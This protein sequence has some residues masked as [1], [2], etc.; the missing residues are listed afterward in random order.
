[1]EQAAHQ[2]M[3]LIANWCNRATSVLK[4]WEEWANDYRIASLGAPASTLEGLVAR[5]ESLT[6]DLLKL[7]RER[8]HILTQEA[9]G[10]FR[11]LLVKYPAASTGFSEQFN[12]VE[13]LAARVRQ[14]CAAQWISIRQSSNFVDELLFMFKSGQSAPATYSSDEQ[15]AFQGGYL[16]D[17][18]A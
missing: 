16:L 2:W 11:E 8:Q 12:L 1:M 5:G 6:A 18:E 10:S 4:H 9:I 15:T 14:V 7:I 13:S 3:D 17:S